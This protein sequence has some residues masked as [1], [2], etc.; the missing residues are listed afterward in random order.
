M[1]KPFHIQDRL[2]GLA[3]RLSSRPAATGV[4]LISAGGLG[5]TVLFSLVLPRL[6]RLAQDGEQV[7]LLIRREAAKMAFLLPPEITVMAVDFKLLR[8]SLSYRRK[9]FRGLFNRHFRLVIST[10][11]LRHP[12]LDES[13]VRAAAPDQAVA[14]EPRS[15]PKHDRALGQNR[16]LYQRL[17]ASGPDHLDKVIRWS[18][19]ADWLSG[20]AEAAPMVRIAKGRIAGNATSDTPDVLIQPFSAVK[21]KQSPVALYR[22][23][24][25]RL[26]PATRIVLT[27]APGDLENNPEFKTLLE[28]PNVEFDPSTFA[29]LA[30]KLVAARLVIS[31]DTALMHL[32]IALGAPTIGLASAAYVGEIVPYAPEITPPNAHILFK[33]MDCQGCLGA[34]PKAPQDGMYPC[35]A[36]LDHDRIMATVDEILVD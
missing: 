17:F 1:L 11:H 14:M 29:D 27:G 21:L 22:K 24:I 8:K 23:I 2:Q 26:P 9:Q 20:T 30:P 16:A 19:F 34:C 4:L 7:T 6:A 18:T 15:W 33:P 5:D 28:Y 31:V 13:L 35:V 36:G 12:D 32:A 25:E 10:D 3:R